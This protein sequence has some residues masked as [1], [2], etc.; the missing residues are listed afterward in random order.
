MCEPALIVHVLGF[1]T[2][3]EVGSVLRGHIF[4]PHKWEFYAQH[5]KNFVR[6]TKMYGR[7]YNNDQNSEGVLAAL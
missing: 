1:S 3:L 7:T 2:L 6:L 5:N 4:V